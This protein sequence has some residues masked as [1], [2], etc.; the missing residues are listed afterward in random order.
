MQDWGCDAI[1]AAEA[2][3]ARE[4]VLALNKAS[5]HNPEMIGFGH[6]AF[7][8]KYTC[9]SKRLQVGTIQN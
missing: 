6:A 3:E 1:G 5:I 2:I 9:I 4:L 8:D 7:R